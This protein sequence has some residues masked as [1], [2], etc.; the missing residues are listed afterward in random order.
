MSKLT[1][2]HIL[3]LSLNWHTQRKTGDLLH[4]LDRG[5]PVNRFGE[6]IGFTV[7]P[8]LL[9]VA[10]AVVV[11]IIRFELA[12]G[13][14][15]GVVMNGYIWIS[16]VLTK[17][18]TRIRKRMDD[19]DAIIRTDCLLNYETVRYF[20]GEEYE[21]RRYAGAIGEY[22][23]SERGFNFTLNLLVLLQTL[24][25]TLGLLISSIIVSSR[26]T[27]GEGNTSDF[28]VFIAYYAQVA[29]SQFGTVYR[30]INQSLID[31]EKLL[32]LLAE[33]TEVVD[34]PD[35]K[36][37]LV[38]KS[39]VEFGNVSFSYDGITPVL[40]SISFKLPPGG[41]IA[42]PG[43][44][45]ILIDG[46]DI[47]TVTLSSLRNAI[48]VVLQDPILF[49]ASIGYNIAYGRPS[50]MPHSQS[51]I[52]DAAKAAQMHERIMSFPEGYETKVGERDGRL[53]DGEKCRL[54]IARAMVE[55]PRVLL[56][57]E[58]T[59][60]LDGATERAA[61]LR[62]VDGRSCLSIPH[63]LSAITGTD[64]I[65]VL[66]EGRVVEQGSRKELLELNGLFA[67]MWTDQISTPEEPMTYEAPVVDVPEP[68][69][70]VT[71][72]QIASPEAAPK[73]NLGFSFLMMH[74]YSGGPSLSPTPDSPSADIPGHPERSH[75]QGTSVTFGAGAINTPPRAASPEPGSGRKVAYGISGL[76]DG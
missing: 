49:D 44:G 11:F 17:Y 29:L 42:L 4:M 5:T 74:N 23:A 14:V 7:L 19:R 18:R 6:L 2:N 76:R 40:K 22:Q 9:D 46:Q 56:L 73:E 71:E 26:I 43:D 30:S 36:E 53:G 62:L 24:I 69:S 38:A 64:V 39:Q 70:R 45:R 66:K 8:P 51:T 48:G 63:R 21:A 75:A 15:V 55:N 72:G 20:G 1:F 31:T 60:A 25:L 35:A 52:I 54:A 33:P 13:V 57:D 32:N 34:A 59:S 3:A 67:S 50:T 47:R 27:R 10:V 41:R 37:L 61:L 65:V 58:V 16:V 28:V 12:L 68:E